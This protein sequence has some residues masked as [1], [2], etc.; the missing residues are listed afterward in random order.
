MKI[1][2]V[3][4]AESLGVSHG[5]EFFTSAREA[6]ACARRFKAEHEDAVV[7][8]EPAMVRLT[9]GGIIRMLEAWARHPDN[10]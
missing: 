3:H 10:G 2:R 9:K 7:N 5:Y 8:V 4:L 6:A 1:Y